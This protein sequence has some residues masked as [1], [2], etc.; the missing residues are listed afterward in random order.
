[1]S[2]YRYLCLC[3]GFPGTGQFKT[4]DPG[5]ENAGNQNAWDAHLMQLKIYILAD[6]KCQKHH[7]LKVFLNNFKILLLSKYAQKKI[8]LLNIFQQL[9]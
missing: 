7:L 4:L 2:I 3:T 9:R 5:L 6:N 1:M 8:S